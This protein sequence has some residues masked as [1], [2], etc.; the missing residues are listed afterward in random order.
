MGHEK[1]IFLISIFFVL[2]YTNYA[3]A[4]INNLSQTERANI[5]LVVDNMEEMLEGIEVLRDES[6]RKWA[7]IYQDEYDKLEAIKNNI[8]HKLPN[9]IKSVP[10]LQDEPPKKYRHNGNASSPKAAY[11]GDGKTEIRNADGTWTHCSE[12]TII[13]DDGI[14][15]PGNGQPINE[16]TFTGWQTK[17][18]LAHVLVHEKYHEKVIN[19][20]IQRLHERGWWNHLPQSEKER[21]TQNAITRSTTAEKHVEVYQEQKNFLKIYKNTLIHDLK[22][23][24]DQERDLKRQ[25]APQVEI[26]QVKQQIVDLKN[27]IKWLKERHSQLETAMRNAVR[28]SHLGF[29]DCGWHAKN[30]TGNVT[31]AIIFPAGFERFDFSVENNQIVDV[32]ITD[33]VWYGVY[34]QVSEIIVEPDMYL[35]MPSDIFSGIIFQPNVC[36]FIENS[37]ESEEILIS[38]T[39]FD[40]FIVNTKPR[41]ETKSNTFVNANTSL[42]AGSGFA[43]NSEIVISLKNENQD[44]IVS[45][46]FSDSQGKFAEKIW[47]NFSNGSAQ[48]EVEDIFGNFATKSVK[49]INMVH[50]CHA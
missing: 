22:E 41:I 40:A 24:K 44:R 47:I 50:H 4:E 38:E 29:E 48:L 7:A 27:K 2:G 45:V 10:G 33:T 6:S 37:M 46:I 26:D 23:L 35:Q 36:N 3:Y 15:D 16:N 14:L 25:Q 18:D 20:E 13:V 19:D 34:E 8:E 31:I 49:I 1:L 5:Q 39:A 43:P 30:M 32:Q 21:H 11:C 12:G 17:W 28:G 9:E 42:L